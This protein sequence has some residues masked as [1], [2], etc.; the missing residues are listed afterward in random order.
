MHLYEH[1]VRRS[2]I[3][4]I[5]VC[6]CSSVAF[7]QAKATHVPLNVKLGLWEMTTVV[8]M[9][10]APAVD[11]SGMS[12]AQKAQVEAA[13]S[14]MQQNLAKPQVNRTCVT[15]EKV[16]GDLFQDAKQ[17]SCKRSVLESTSTTLGLKFECAGP[18]PSSGEVHF[19][20]VSPDVIKATSKMLIDGKQSVATTST[21]KWIGEACGD[22]K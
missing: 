5:A 18:R 12:A 10:G 11:T 21:G 15:K 20:A 22:V 17:E 7:A 14:S 13:M 19:V 3:V 6:F 4:V 9:S 8:Q 1:A 2:L 16:E